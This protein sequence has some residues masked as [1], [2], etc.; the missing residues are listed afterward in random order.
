MA[1]AHGTHDSHAAGQLAV[2]HGPLGPL[3][4]PSEPSLLAQLPVMPSSSDAK[5]TPQTP[6]WHTPSARSCRKLARSAPRSMASLLWLLIGDTS[7]KCHAVPN[8][9]MCSRNTHG[10][11]G[12]RPEP[13]QGL[14]EAPLQSTGACRVGVGSASCPQTQGPLDKVHPRWRLSRLASLRSGQ[15]ALRTPAPPEDGT[16][17]R[18]SRGSVPRPWRPCAHTIAPLPNGH[19]MVT[20]DTNNPQSRPRL[21]RTRQYPCD[22]H[23]PADDPL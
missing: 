3:P 23:Y 16:L 7:A 11:R 4:S 8:N 2:G 12:V 22:I 17:R 21:W 6:A 13:E 1:A 18:K 9:T 5:K 15:A 19:G 14:R 10:A 20:P